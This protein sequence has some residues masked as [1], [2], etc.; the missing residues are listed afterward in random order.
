MTGFCA[1]I[2]QDLRDWESGFYAER[3]KALQ[4]DVGGGAAEEE[5]KGECADGEEEEE[6]PVGFLWA[7][8]PE[9]VWSRGRRRDGAER[10]GGVGIRGAVVECDFEEKELNGDH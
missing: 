6:V 2:L 1:V 10:S 8:L 4:G 9:V 5:L 7:P 3:E